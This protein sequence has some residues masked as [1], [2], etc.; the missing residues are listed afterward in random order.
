MF[1]N[2][3]SSVRLFAEL[4]VRYVTITHVCHT[5]LLSLF[6]YLGIIADFVTA[7]AS[8]NGGGGPME[9]V[10]VGNALTDLGRELVSELNRLGGKLQ[11]DLEYSEH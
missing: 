6:H 1:G 3:L 2:S 5:G 9:P 8:S 7:F 11:F 10:H 4:G